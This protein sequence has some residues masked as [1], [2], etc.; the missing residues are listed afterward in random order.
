MAE[1]SVFF[2]WEQDFFSEIQNESDNLLT[3]RNDFEMRGSPLSRSLLMWQRDTESWSLADFGNETVYHIE[4][5]NDRVE[6]SE[7]TERWSVVV[8]NPIDL[9]SPS[10]IDGTHEGFIDW[11]LTLARLVTLNQ[12]S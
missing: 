10:K 3:L 7:R 6:V 5:N 8:G 9:L 12:S 11:L 4:T 2:T 1:S